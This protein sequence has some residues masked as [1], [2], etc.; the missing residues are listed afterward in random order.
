LNHDEKRE[1]ESTQDSMVHLVASPCQ[2]PTFYGYADP[3]GKPETLQ[4]RI[5]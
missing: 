5:T 1:Q 4:N 2:Q 3:F